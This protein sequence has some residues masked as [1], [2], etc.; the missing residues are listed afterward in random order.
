[1]L[2]A[3]SLV[4]VLA[5]ASSVLAAP[6]PLDAAGGSEPAVRALP[7][8]MPRIGVRLLKDRQGPKVNEHTH[9]QMEE[10]ES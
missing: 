4:L 5:L 1:M 8:A 10:S 6:F 7:R 2:P 9:T 3:F